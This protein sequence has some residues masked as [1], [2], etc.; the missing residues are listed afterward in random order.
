M[1]DELFKF[2][3][4]LYYQYRAKELYLYLHGYFMIFITIILMRMIVNFIDF[5]LFAIIVTFIF[6]Y[7]VIYVVFND[8]FIIFFTFTIFIVNYLIILIFLA[9]LEFRK[10]LFFTEIIFAIILILFLSLL[11]LISLFLVLISLA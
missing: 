8:F 5:H 3:D 7:Y 11:Y 9:N 10:C 2:A 1:L 4:G 6:K